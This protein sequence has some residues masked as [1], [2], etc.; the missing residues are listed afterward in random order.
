MGCQQGPFKL[1]LLGHFGMTGRLQRYQ[2]IC[3]IRWQLSVHT[4]QNKWTSPPPKC[5]VPA[6]PRRNPRHADIGR[7]G[8]GPWLQLELA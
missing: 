1:S 8:S 7:A 5:C 2:P 6:R 3:P 4:E